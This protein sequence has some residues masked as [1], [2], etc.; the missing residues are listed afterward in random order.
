MDPPFVTFANKSCEPTSDPC[1]SGWICVDAECELAD[2]GVATDGGVDA[3]PPD[4]GPPDGGH[5]DGG[6]RDAGS[7]D[8]GSDAG[9]DAGL[10]CGCTP[11]QALCDANDVTLE[12]CVAPPD[13]GCAFYVP[14]LDCSDGGLVC[15][16]SALACRCPA[17]ASSD[18]YVDP[19]QGGDANAGAHATGLREPPACRLGTLTQAL[20]LAGAAAPASVIAISDPVDGGYPS[21]SMATFGDAAEDGGETFPLTLPP[22]VTLET[23][24]PDASYTFVTEV[25]AGDPTLT[26]CVIESAG[27]GAAI[28]NVGIQ[29]QT[30]NASGICCSGGSLTLNAGDL[31]FGAANGDTSANGI[32]ADDGCQLNL[33]A[34]D[35]V[36]GFPGDGVRL[37]PAAGAAL[38][39][40]P[41]L[42]QQSGLAGVAVLGGSLTDGPQQP[43]SIAS[44]QNQG[45]GLTVS[46]GTVDLS[47]GLA[48]LT[49]YANGDH[50]IEL[51]GSSTTVTLSSVDV[52]GAAVGTAAASLILVAA[53]TLTIN[54]GNVIGLSDATPCVQAQGSSV[55]SIT[56]AT[57]QGGAVGLAF[58]GQQA[59]L[60][61]VMVTGSSGTGISIAGNGSVSLLG[62]TL[63]NNTGSGLVVSPTTPNLIVTLKNNLVQDN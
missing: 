50:G 33:G 43:G 57:V 22:L 19:Y 56:G 34:Y 47:G 1:P 10:P 11:G 39:T 63:S 48:A 51:T 12:T 16:P 17:N 42:V 5:T 25:V 35:S 13:G 58:S 60:T 30:P 27:S 52:Q 4:A 7:P 18:F 2:A 54:G 38:L 40:A 55:L 14:L 24:E 23:W 29:V 45:D 49:A 37:G 61:D 44:V 41:L 32:D 21:R 9:S 36:T 8:A 28:E 59:T 31:Y 20:A 46:G 6:P 26:T 15:S 3:G 53:G 62:C